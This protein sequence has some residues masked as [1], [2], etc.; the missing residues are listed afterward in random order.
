MLDHVLSGV[1]T[2][3][4]CPSP[5]NAYVTEETIFNQLN[6]GVRNRNLIENTFD[7]NFVLVLLRSRDNY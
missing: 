4:R 7:L 3:E 5:Q 2:P 6:S 1:R